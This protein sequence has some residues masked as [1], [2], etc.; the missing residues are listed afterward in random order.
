VLKI[1]RQH[2]EN[3]NAAMFYIFVAKIK[4]TEISEFYIG[5][6]NVAT[7]VVTMADGHIHRFRVK[8][9]A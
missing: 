2:S 5:R 6:P 1:T 4:K 9:Q 8:E 3:L 7:S